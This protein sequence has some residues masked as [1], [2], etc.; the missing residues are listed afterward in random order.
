MLVGLAVSGLANAATDS[1]VISVESG[2]WE[3]EARTARVSVLFQSQPEVTKVIST[4]CLNAV[5]MPSARGP[6]RVFTI[7]IDYEARDCLRMSSALYGVDVMGFQAD[8]Y[9]GAFME[10]DACL[11]ARARESAFFERQT[12][13]N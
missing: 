3:C 13:L 11:A 5:E 1:A 6:Y 8:N 7:S 4:D 2:G 12:G 10:L 9:E